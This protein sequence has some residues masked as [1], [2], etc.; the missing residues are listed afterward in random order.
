[1]GALNMTTPFMPTVTLSPDGL[2]RIEGGEIVTWAEC[3]LRLTARIPT[4]EGEVVKPTDIEW[5]E[6]DR[7]VLRRRIDDLLETNNRYLERARTAEAALA[8]PV[9]PVG[10]RERVLDELDRAWR[11]GQRRTLWRRDESAG[12]ILAALRQ[13]VVP[14]V[15]EE[16]ARIIDPVAWEALDLNGSDAA[17]FMGFSTARSLAKADAILAALRPTDTGRE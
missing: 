1:M 17:D 5:L 15:R 9:F 4:P 11:H 14:V 7:R 12:A 6:A 8:S 13:L 16:I 3:E 10:V 2:V